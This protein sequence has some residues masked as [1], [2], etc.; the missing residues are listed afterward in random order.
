MA[1]RMYLKLGDVAGTSGDKEHADWIEIA[2]FGTGVANS[3]NCVEKAMG[4][5]G[6]EACSH[7]DI[8]TTKQVD[9]TSPQLAAYCSVGKMW[10]E[11]TIEVFEEKDLLYQIVLNNVAISSV[12]LSGGT[13]DVPY[14]TL[15][16]AFSKITWKYKTEA[17]QYWDLMANSGSLEK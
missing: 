13:G 11:A 9:K 15:V 17:E 6:G 10:D 7:Q 5:P 4:N 12:G 2:S 8:S 14:E 3:I 16:L 1:T